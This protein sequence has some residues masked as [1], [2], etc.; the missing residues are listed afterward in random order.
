MSLYQERN[1]RLYSIASITSWLCFFVQG[2]AVSWLTWKLSHSAGTLGLV[3]F[4]SVVPYFIFGPWASVLADRHSRLKILLVAYFL[5]FVQGMALAVT[6]YFEVL[7]VP[8]LAALTFA[9]GAILAFSVPASYGLLPRAVS[10]ENLSAAIAFSSS[11]R[12]LAMFLGPA[13]AGVLLAKFPVSISFLVNALAYLLFLV[14]LAKMRLTSPVAPVA[15]SGTSVL[16]DY[17]DGLR[18]A[19]KH[20]MVGLLLLL[21]FFNDGLRG[22]TGKLMPVFADR[23]FPTAASSGLALLAGVTGVGAALASIALS[24]SR[25]HQKSW[26]II[27][28]GFAFAVVT[29]ISFVATNSIWQATISRLVFGIAAESTLTSTLILLQSNLDDRFRSRVMGNAF[30]VSQAA[31]LALIGVGPMSALIGLNQ[32]IYCF[33]TLATVALFAFWYS[34][35]RWSHITTNWN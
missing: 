17:L 30:L 15:S 7:N 33:C 19:M 25:S 16:G 18:Y 4:L 12:T 27:Q 2:L 21:T 8:M 26:Y 10:R 34:F 29:T 35:G 14:V 22:L 24:R 31:S 11:Y 28:L 23:I 20:P 9:E 32:V 13:L 3:S 5:A 1:F 6:S